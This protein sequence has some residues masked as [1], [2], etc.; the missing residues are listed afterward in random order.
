MTFTFF[1]NTFLSFTLLSV[2]RGVNSLAIPWTS[3]PKEPIAAAWYAGWHATKGFPLSSIP[4]DKYNTLIYSFATT[5]PSVDGLSLDGSE[6][7]VFPDFV[8]QAHEHGVA[9]HISIG[10]WSGGRYFSSNLATPE[11]RTAFVQ[12]LANFADKYNLDGINFDWEYPNNQGIGCNIINVNDT[13]NFLSFLQEF[14]ANPVGASLTLSAATPVLP[15]RDATGKSS[16]DVSGF[17]DVLD[18][19]AIMNYDVWGSWSSFV[20]PNAPL[21]DTCAASANQEGSA[22][23]AVKA[24]TA[25]G[26]PA[27]KI[28]LGVAAYGHSFSVAPSDAFA[29]GSETELVAYPKFNSSNQPL[30]GSWDNTGGVDACGVFEPQGG[31]FTFWNLIDGGFLTSDGKAARSIYYRY[32]GCSQTPYIYN[33]ISEVMISFDNP[34]SFSAKGS[35]IA[36][37]GLAGFVMWEAGGD[38]DDLLL[39]AIRATS[40]FTS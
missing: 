38:Y 33:K 40:G 24:W 29:D 3:C 31:T 20:G 5:T 27:D 1:S 17:A 19:I 15:F 26:M 8:S 36:E 10:G 14:R 25:A 32:D 39:A 22:V 11:N 2:L 23:S 6:P 21:N 37:T 13:E 34:Q 30:G 9:A 35:Y 12:T 18:Y 28:V 4:W 16:T 7:S